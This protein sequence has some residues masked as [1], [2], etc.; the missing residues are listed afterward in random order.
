MYQHI[1][2]N[3]LISIMLEHEQ[4]E[5]EIEQEIEQ[6]ETI[7]FTEIFGGALGP[8]QPGYDFGETDATPI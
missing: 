3:R 6:D 2:F 7:D 5:E 8:S 4:I 1:L